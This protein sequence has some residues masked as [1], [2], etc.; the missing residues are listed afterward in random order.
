MLTGHMLNDKR[1]K[2]RDGRRNFEV[3]LDQIERMASLASAAGVHRP[4]EQ[5]ERERE[6]GGRRQRERERERTGGTLLSLLLPRLFLLV[7]VFLLAAWCPP[8]T[9]ATGAIS[10][11]FTC[12]ARWRLLRFFSCCTSLRPSVVS[13]RTTLLDGLEESLGRLSTVALR[14]TKVVS[15]FSSTTQEGPEKKE[16]SQHTHTT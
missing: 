15:I 12:F 6:R 8:F 11:F 14:H 13:Q 9:H 2:C 4:I 7:V 1:Q 10:F 3:T 5:L 16:K